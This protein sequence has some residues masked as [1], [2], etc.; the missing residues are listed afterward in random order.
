MLP[1]LS[2]VLFEQADDVSFAKTTEEDLA[3]VVHAW[4][5]ISKLRRLQTTPSPSFFARAETSDFTA[6]F[7]IF[8]LLAAFAD[9]LSSC[10]VYIRSSHSAASQ[11]Q[12]L[13]FMLLLVLF[14]GSSYEMALV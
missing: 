10:S 2:L 4:V 7:L 9:S 8:R 3:C 13:H 1:I 11:R 12:K 5:N 6:I 14:S